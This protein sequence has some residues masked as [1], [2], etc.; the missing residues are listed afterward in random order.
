MRFDIGLHTTPAN[1]QTQND[2]LP[3]LNSAGQSE[4]HIS[5]GGGPDAQS[6]LAATMPV[7]TLLLNLRLCTNEYVPSSALS[8]FQTTSPSG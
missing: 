4:S 2:A 3:R 5:N 6:L 8:V 1:L 7:R